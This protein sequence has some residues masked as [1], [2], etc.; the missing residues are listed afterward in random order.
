MGFHFGLGECT[1]FRAYL[2][3]DWDV[4]WGYGVLTHGQMTMGNFSHGT[5]PRSFAGLHG[6]LP[7]AIWSSLWPF[8]Q[9][10]YDE[11]FRNI[12]ALD[13]SDAGSARLPR[14]FTDWPCGSA[15]FPRFER[16]ASSEPGRHRVHAPEPQE[17]E[18]GASLAWARL[19]EC[20]E[21]TR[22]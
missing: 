9:D 18:R 16:V 6:S 20:R 8:G 3:G 14:G 1:H 12:T 11:G 21:T 4:H 2:S 19:A 13:I 15:V 22:H 5:Y 7:L 10:M 17:A